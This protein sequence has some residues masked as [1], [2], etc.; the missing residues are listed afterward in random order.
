MLKTF[1]NQNHLTS[2]SMEPYIFYAKDARPAESSFSRFAVNHRTGRNIVKYLFLLTTMLLLAVKPSYGIH[3]FV[4]DTT[5]TPVPAAPAPAPPKPVPAAAQA[6]PVDTANPK[7]AKKIEPRVIGAYKFGEK[8]E[9]DKSR[10]FA[11]INDLIV[12]EVQGLQ[13]L[14]SKSTCRDAEGNAI[15]PCTPRKILLYLDGRQIEGI[16]PESGAPRPE[17]GT[18]RF[19]LER[20]VGTN[21]RI[22]ADLLGAPK[23]GRTFFKRPTE[24]SV[25]FENEFPVP[26][27]VKEDRFQIVR[28]RQMWFWGCTIGIF[29]MLYY[30]YS[31]ATKS[32]ILRDSGPTDPLGQLKPYS[33]ARCQMAFWFFWVVISFLYLWLIT[34]A[35]DI[36]T[37]EA[38][39]LIGI[40]TATALGAASI[41][42]SKT[43]EVATETKRLEEQIVALT[44][45]ITALNTQITAIPAPLDLKEL[46]Q[47]RDA[48]STQLMVV[49][50][51]LAN[52]T[53]TLAPRVSQGWRKDLL[54]DATGASF[55]RFQIVVWTFIL[56]LLFI[57]SVWNRLS[58]PE[59]GATLLGLQGISAATYI[60]FKIPEKRA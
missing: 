41:D 45:E 54:N 42:S 8:S 24:V 27:D 36:I 6:T 34:G 2:T 11:G 57:F 50:H 4:Q 49:R 53:N 59:F 28:I 55:H 32:D 12:V 52:L 15:T 19:R 60:G 31:L 5:T 44:A 3:V 40:G 23:M 16:A 9:D 56:G 22:W 29:I 47:R 48:T 20:T 46:T 18:L 25:G 33:L 37:T 30:L 39:T 14:V 1:R 13:E 17:E 7:P 26:T 21:D 10:N 58:M 38:L 43:E 51:Q 35:Y